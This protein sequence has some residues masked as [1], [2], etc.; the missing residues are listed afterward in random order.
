VVRRSRQL[1]KAPPDWPTVSR[2]GR[3][4]RAAFIKLRLGNLR[5]EWR[6]WLGFVLMAFLAAVF[7]VRLGTIGMVVGG[8]MIGSITAMMVIGWTI[9]FDVHAFPWLW[10]SWGEEQTA[11]ELRKL[12]PDWYVAHNI[13]ND[14]GNW[15]HI[16]VGPAGVFL[17]DSKHL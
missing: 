1:S 14:H 5:R 9:G 13:A 4:A 7:M 10:G 6:T 12:G 15:D 3:S 11:E 17:V 2:G 16:V 8:W